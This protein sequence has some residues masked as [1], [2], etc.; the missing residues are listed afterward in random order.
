MR[1]IQWSYS[2]VLLLNGNILFMGSFIK[3]LKLLVEAEIWNLD[4]PRNGKSCN[5]G[6]LQRSATF[7]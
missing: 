4:Y 5:P 7:Y 2:L 6:I 1:R 3:N